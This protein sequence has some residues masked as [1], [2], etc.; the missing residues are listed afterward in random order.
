[1]KSIYYFAYGSNMLEKVISG[2]RGILYHRKMS[3]LAKGWRLVFN[4]PGVNKY[5]PAFANIEK[6][7][8]HD[9]EGV[10]YH[11]SSEN[12]AQLTK[13]EGSM[14]DI[15]DIDVRLTNGTMLN[16]KT[17]VSD[18]LVKPNTPSYR[19]LR[20]LIDGAKENDL[21]WNYINM[22]SSVSHAPTP[23]GYS[24]ICFLVSIYLRLRFLLL[25]IKG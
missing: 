16:A 11:M 2:R 19:Y 8:D 14:Y 10:V 25:K 12:F 21:F 18:P 22:L 20:L 15:V 17:L 13:T 1:M 23:P 3:G 4:C 5:E 9:V 6:N 24:F 7:D